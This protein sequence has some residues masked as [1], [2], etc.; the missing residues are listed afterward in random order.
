MQS[1]KAV[2]AVEGTG[3]GVDWR[4]SQFVVVWKHF[5]HVRYGGAF[6]APHGNPDMVDD[7]PL[8]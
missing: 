3:W 6:I 5:C 4:R 1:E 7:M 2:N 8:S